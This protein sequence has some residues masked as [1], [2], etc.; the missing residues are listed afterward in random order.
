MKTQRLDQLSDGIFAIIMTLLALELKVPIVADHQD[1]ASL[2]GELQ[3]LGPTFGSFVL[4]FA[5]LF[6]YWRAHHFLTSMYAKNLTVG[7]A[8]YNALFFLFIAM[9]P[10]SAKLLGEYPHNNMAVFAYGVN[11]IAIGL[12]L[13]FMRRHIEKNPAIDTAP[14]TKTEYRSGYIRILFPIFIAF[15]GIMLSFVNTKISI[16]LFSIS[17]VFNII[18]ASS[19]FIHAW[20]DRMF[21]DDNEIMESNFTDVEKRL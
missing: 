1:A 13:Y 4:S 14:I 17:I 21:S 3:K 2:F 11:V 12:T 8:N 10:F 18:P 20:L 6:T 15:T 9:V 5:L 7:L 19:N 16:T